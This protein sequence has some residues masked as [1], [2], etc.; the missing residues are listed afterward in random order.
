MLRETG[1]SMD[2]TEGVVGQLR[3]IAGVELAV[4]LKEY[5]PEEIKVSL[6]SKKYVDVAKFSSDFNGGGHERAAGF[7]LR[8]PIA[9][10]FDRVRE[11]VNNMPEMK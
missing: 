5:G 2:E 4:F 8:C 3:S 6:R 9:E 1:A 11:Y 10:A 7:T